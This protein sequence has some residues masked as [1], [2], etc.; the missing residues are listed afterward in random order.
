MMTTDERQTM[1]DSAESGGWH[2]R[3]LDPHRLLR[4][5]GARVQVV[6]HGTAAISG[7]LALPRR[8]PHRVHAGI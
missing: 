1:A 5:G 6:W 3:N 4:Q 8:R 7:R 2:R